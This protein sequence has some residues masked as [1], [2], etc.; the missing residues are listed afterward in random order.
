MSE[1]QVPIEPVKNE[2]KEDL[3]ERMRREFFEEK[4]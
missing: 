4:P 2:V 1:K 3:F